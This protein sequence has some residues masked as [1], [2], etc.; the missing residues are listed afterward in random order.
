M[1]AREAK[2]EPWEQQDGETSK[3]FRAFAI[4]RDMGPDRSQRKVAA[5]LGIRTN[6][7]DRWATKYHWVER[8]SEWGRE[9]DRTKC[10]AA[11]KEIE[12]M[13]VRHA[14]LAVTMQNKMVDRLV[15]LSKDDVDKMSLTEM[16]QWLVDSVKLERL[17]RGEPESIQQ[18]NQNVKK[19]DDDVSLEDAEV[20]AKA[21]LSA[22]EREKR[23]KAEAPAA[24]EPGQLVVVP[25]GKT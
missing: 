13:A 22:I 23:A 18:Q 4:Y 1:S 25:G 21:L 7:T 8:V 17:A 20:R 16:R 10:K 14:R 3:A 5:E 6:T 15:G 24:V 12:D 2:I 11:L 9:Q 19:V